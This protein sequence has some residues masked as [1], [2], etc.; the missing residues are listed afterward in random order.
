MG[1]TRE[2]LKKLGFVKHANEFG[3]S[4][5]RDTLVYKSTP[6]KI[7]VFLPKGKTVLFYTHGYNPTTGT[8]LNPLRLV[9]LDDTSFSEMK[10]FLKSL[11]KGPIVPPKKLL[12][13]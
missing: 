12:I 2:H 8:P 11:R 6:N 9:M 1:I 4:Q 10:V 5:D 13:D 7:L 3:L